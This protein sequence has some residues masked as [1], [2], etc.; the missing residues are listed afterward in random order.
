MI[1]FQQYKGVQMQW[2]DKE[3]NMCYVELYRDS[4]LPFYVIT[5]NDSE[6]ADM[7]YYV[8]YDPVTITTENEDI[9][10]PLFYCHAS[11][12]ITC[13]D[14]LLLDFVCSNEMTC[15]I[16]KT[17]NNQRVNIFSGIV[18]TKTYQQDYAEKYTTFEIVS[19]DYIAITENRKYKNWTDYDQAK[20]QAT[21]Q[22]VSTILTNIFMG[23][24]GINIYLQDNVFGNKRLSD[25]LIN[26]YM[27][28][29]TE[30]DNYKNNQEMLF[31]ICRYF[32]I[33]AIACYRDIYL[34]TLPCGTSTFTNISNTSDVKTLNINNIAITKDDYSG[35]DTQITVLDRV[36]NA[37]VNVTFDT[38]GE[39]ISDIVESDKQLSPYMAYYR[40][41]KDIEDTTTGRESIYSVLE[42]EGITLRYYDRY[43]NQVKEVK[44]LYNENDPL[45]IFRAAAWLDFCPVLYTSGDVEVTD[46]YDY[47]FKNRQADLSNVIGIS[48]PHNQ[49][50]TYTQK[51]SGYAMPAMDVT[52]WDNVRNWQTALYNAGGMIE[53]DIDN[54]LLNDVDEDETLFILFQGKVNY[55]INALTNYTSMTVNG[56]GNPFAFIQSEL[57]LDPQ[58]N[59]MMYIKDGFTSD[60]G[61]G[62]CI[63]DYRSASYIFDYAYTSQT[64]PKKY[65]IYEEYP[66]GK[67]ND[68]IKTRDRSVQYYNIPLSPQGESIIRPVTLGGQQFK[69]YG[70]INNISLKPEDFTGTN[71][72]QKFLIKDAPKYNLE[73]TTM[74]VKGMRDYYNFKILKM[75]LLVC[76]MKVGDKY[77]CEIQDP[78]N[79]K[80]TKFVWL[81]AEEATQQG[82]TNKTFTIGTIPE[83]D[84]YITNDLEFVN[85][86]VDS[87]LLDNGEAI[88]VKRSDHLEGQIEFRIIAPYFH[89][90][91]VTT[92][93]HYDSSIFQVLTNQWREW[94]GSSTT[95]INPYAPQ[96]F[97]N[98]YWLMAMNQYN[99][100]FPC[101]T[102]MFDQ[103]LIKSFKA[104]IA[105]SKTGA[106]SSDNT[107]AD[108]VYNTTT[109]HE[110]DFK[111]EYEFN[112]MSDMT[113]EMKFLEGI[114]ML[115]AWN[116][117]YEGTVLDATTVK[118]ITYNDGIQTRNDIV[119]EQ[120][121]CDRM[122]EQRTDMS[123][124]MSTSTY[125]NSPQS[126]INTYSFGYMGNDK[127]FFPMEREYNPTMNTI[128]QRMTQVR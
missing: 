8:T 104:S 38:Y 19:D 3:G 28:F 60:Y 15:D 126:S 1:D 25:Y 93:E 30:K 100:A 103:M 39:F 33:Y 32:N 58:T 111:K 125:Q 94:M 54:S 63:R 6:T 85:N 16:Y 7:P 82:I 12:R 76:E 96:C 107:K 13:Q 98:G 47:Q 84:T 36:T 95:Y 24:D 18:T 5:A 50:P 77:C 71:V 49:Y 109:D 52:L 83:Q 123:Y 121:M 17:V 27:F 99:E 73:D 34:F 90:T 55:I 86:K 114:T 57:L 23:F 115:P 44:D 87:V 68:L 65:I 11:I 42:N 61:G 51:V 128:W 31:A 74:K 29:G 102:M 41:C 59:K 62:N 37:N 69:T 9:S 35:N 101:I 124:E 122:T 80:Y 75:P 110:K 112:I 88:P 81:T 26:E 46:L 113:D 4:A 72:W 14:H 40:W 22:P 117:M 97:E 67:L 108:Y 119:P 53:I 91:P 2:K 78:D 120:L 43:D 79:E 66:K 10:N 21:R 116:T 20:A 105:T 89:T 92:T 127:K 106:V 118:T 45:E 48:L 70:H 56:Q 64:D